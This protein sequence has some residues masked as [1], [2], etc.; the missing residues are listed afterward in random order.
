MDP[1]DALMALSPR[2]GEVT[3]RTDDILQVRLSLIHACILTFT[4]GSFEN[5]HISLSRR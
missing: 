5:I 3:L 4:N 2:D 1:D